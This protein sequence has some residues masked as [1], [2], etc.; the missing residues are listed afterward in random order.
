MSD[1]R[2]PPQNTSTTRF[3]DLY[4]AASG[5]A[6]NRG[7]ADAMIAMNCIKNP[8]A[9]IARHASIPKRALKTAP[10]AAPSGRAP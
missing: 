3:I 7:G 5:S 10:I 1:L 6:L 4:S 9:E 8:N 2:Y